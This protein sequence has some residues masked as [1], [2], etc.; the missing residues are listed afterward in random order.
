M[1][2]AMPEGRPGK[3]HLHD[4][5][6]QRQLRPPSSQRAIRVLA[7]LCRHQRAPC[8]MAPSHLQIYDR[9][10]SFFSR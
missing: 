4:M 5:P 10:F 7:C 6:P 2:R 8:V 1:S 3:H 9:G